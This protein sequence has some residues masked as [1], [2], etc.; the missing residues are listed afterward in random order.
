MF[1]VMILIP[2]PV[3]VFLIILLCLLYFTLSARNS[4]VGNFSLVS[5]R[6]SL[7]HNFVNWTAFFWVSVQCTIYIIMLIF[8]MQ[9]NNSIM[10]KIKILKH[11]FSNFVQ[12]SNN[13][14]FVFIFSLCFCFIIYYDHVHFI[15]ILC[16]ISNAFL[17]IKWV[18][19]RNII[20]L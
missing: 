1:G 12:N 6:F 3:F 10:I 7:I 15:N 20:F 4:S 18:F 17:I 8:F 11:T 19:K 13:S 2:V 14:F 16:Q 9:I 5:K